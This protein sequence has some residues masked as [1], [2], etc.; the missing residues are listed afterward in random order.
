MFFFLFVFFGQVGNYGKKVLLLIVHVLHTGLV[1]AD[2]IFEC[3]IRV[4]KFPLVGYFY[5]FIFM[6]AV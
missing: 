2:I 1:M 5:L 4:K 6:L 3:N